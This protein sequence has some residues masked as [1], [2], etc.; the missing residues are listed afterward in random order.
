MKREQLAQQATDK[1][2]RIIGRVLRGCAAFMPRPIVVAD[3]NLSGVE[4]ECPYR[5]WLL[6]ICINLEG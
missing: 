4:V 2:A 5:T 1:M 6:F 3:E